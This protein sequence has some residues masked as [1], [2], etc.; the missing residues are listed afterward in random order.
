MKHFLYKAVTENGQKIQGM[1]EAKNKDNAVTILREKK[2]LITSLSDQQDNFQ[3]KLFSSFF[4]V[5]EGDIASFTRQFATMVKSGLPMITALQL[6]RNR[7]KP[8]MAELIDDISASVEGGESLYKA[9]SKHNGTFSSIYLALIRASEMAGALDKVMDKLAR[10]MEKEQDFK[11]KV[12]SALL[13]PAIVMVAMVVVGLIMIFFVIP[14]LSSLY[15]EFNAD[16][17]LLTQIVLG[18]TNFIRS[19][20]YIIFGFMVAVVAGFIA[21]LRTPMGKDLADTYILRIPYIGQLQHKIISTNIIG[22]L[23]LLINSGVSIVESLNVVAQAA[24]NNVY[25]RGMTN[26]AQSVEKGMPLSASLSKEDF[27]PDY[28][29]QMVAVGEETGKLDEMLERISRQYEKESLLALK[30]L[31]AAVEPL[32]I[33]I[34]GIGVGILVISIVVPIYNLTSQF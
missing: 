13:Y 26:A 12:K 20:W 27:F 2:L 14:K 28:V 25:T 15:E 3:Y 33:I 10:T 19:Y 34:L 9:L 31:A 16:L 1:V 5:N 7:S 6:L 22:T 4:K 8:A 21:W 32:M 17:P 23:A 29:V 11:A 24:G 18:T 30:A